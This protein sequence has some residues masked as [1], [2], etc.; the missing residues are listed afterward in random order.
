MIIQS[1]E[2]AWSKESERQKKKSKGGKRVADPA[3]KAE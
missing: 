2:L 1:D 3:G